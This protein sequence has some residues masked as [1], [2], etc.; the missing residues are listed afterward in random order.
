[1]T[2]LEC[3]AKLVAA[4]RAGDEKAMRE[5]SQM[6]EKLKRKRRCETCGCRVTNQARFCTQHYIAWRDGHNRK[7]KE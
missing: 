4:H 5:F 3:K 6:R 2:A 1:M 7:L